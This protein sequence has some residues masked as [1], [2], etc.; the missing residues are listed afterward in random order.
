M[1]KPT[2]FVFSN[3]FFICGFFYCWIQTFLSFRLWQFGLNSKMLLMYRLTI[4]VITNLEFIAFV[5]FIYIGTDFKHRHKFQHGF[6]WLYTV[7]LSMFLLSFTGEF[8]K[9]NLKIIV[10]ENQECK[11]KINENE[12]NVL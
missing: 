1:S 11:E 5:T 3:I 8:E 9:V 12:A 10:E 6:E 7:L 4:M 2:H